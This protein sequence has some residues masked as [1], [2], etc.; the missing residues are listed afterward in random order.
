MTPRATWTA[1]AAVTAVA[2]LV[3]GAV[4]GWGWLG[5]AGRE[6]DVRLRHPVTAVRLDVPDASVR[7][8]PGPGGQVRVRSELTWTLHEPRVEKSWQGDR[9]T[10]R[11][12][13]PGPR[14]DGLA[15]N[16]SLDLE[17]PAGASVDARVG[18]GS[19]D[20]AHIR[21]DLDLAGASGALR[22]TDAVGALRLRTT[23]GEIR[24]DALSSPTVR[25]RSDS[26]S[27]RLEFG[28]A[29]R[30]VRAETVSGALSITVPPNSRYRVEP[31]APTSG[32]RAAEGLSDP[33][34][35]RK[36]TVG[37]GSGSATI[38]Y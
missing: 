38:G 18:S 26:G 13:R 19:L 23:S 2:L 35:D 27:T 25:A 22:V 21:G 15:P 10:I 16:V 17:I 9:L 31:G 34:A 24:A 14:L 8:R 36:I 32:L 37:L 6:D 1:L 4:Y 3:P 20:V 7:V 11:V 29:P 28:S 5:R 33:G 30:R 12:T